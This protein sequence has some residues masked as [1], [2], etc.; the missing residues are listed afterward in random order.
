MRR[1]LIKLILNWRYKRECRRWGK[2]KPTYRKAILKV[3]ERQISDIDKQIAEH[4]R[5]NEHLR[6]SETVSDGDS[7][8]DWLVKWLWE[9]CYEGKISDREYHNLSN[10][11]IEK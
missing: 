6:R 7:T 8:L 3:I 2:H 10:S 9:L 4:I 5:Q 11:L 1:I